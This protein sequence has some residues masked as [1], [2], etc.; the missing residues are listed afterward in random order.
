[1]SQKEGLQ[2]KTQKKMTVRGRDDISLNGQH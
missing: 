2:K 1:M